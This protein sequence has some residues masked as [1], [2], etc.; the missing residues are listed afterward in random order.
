ML[1]GKKYR[2][3]KD[4][5]PLHEWIGLN[6]TV[7]ESTDKTREGIKGKIVDE[8]K[9]LIMIETKNGEKKIPKREVKLNI[10]LGNENVLIDCAKLQYRPEDRVKYGGKAYA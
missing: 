1:E 6:A 5:I 10:K 9:N 3:T 7:K 2:I 4:N 8:T